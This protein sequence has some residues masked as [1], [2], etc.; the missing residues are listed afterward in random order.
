[1]LIAHRS[2]LVQLRSGIL[3]L[4]LETGRFQNIKDEN[5]GYFRKLKVMYFM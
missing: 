4:R 3:P 2:L 1:M 5:T